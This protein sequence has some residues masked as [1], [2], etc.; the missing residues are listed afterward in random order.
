[1]KRYERLGQTVG[2]KPTRTYHA[3]RNM[4]QRCT[5][6]RRPDYKYYGARG[7]TVCERWR[8]SF[9]AFLSDMGECPAG[10]SLERKDNTRGYRPDN[11]KWAGRAEQMQNTRG[12]RLLTLNGKSMGLAAWARELGINKESLRTRLIRGWSLARALSTGATK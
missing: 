10:L 7:I 8:L 12:T 5:N 3:W 1:M 2:R 4:I 9:G 11:C 6:L